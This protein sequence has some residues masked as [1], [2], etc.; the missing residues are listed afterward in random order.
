MYVVQVAMKSETMHAVST[1]GSK[2]GELVIHSRGTFEKI[3]LV[4]GSVP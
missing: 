3:T 2:Q 4:W 1:D